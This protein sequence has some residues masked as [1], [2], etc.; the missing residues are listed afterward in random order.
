M[1]ICSDLDEQDVYIE[2]ANHVTVECIFVSS[3]KTHHFHYS[4]THMARSTSKG[5]PIERK[6]SYWSTI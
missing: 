5:R 3:P 2:I 1:G 4:S 6:A